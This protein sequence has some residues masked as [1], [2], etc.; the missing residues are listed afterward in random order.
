MFFPN[1]ADQ[2]GGNAID[3][4]YIF[5]RGKSAVHI[6]YNIGVGKQALTGSIVFDGERVFITFL[7]FQ[8]HCFIGGNE[9][10]AGAETP[11]LVDV[12]ADGL[13]C[14]AVNCR[15]HE[16]GA[17]NGNAQTDDDAVFIPYFIQQIFASC[18]GK[19]I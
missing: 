14:F 5:R 15:Y 10:L 8:Y 4:L 11:Y 12:L 17:K 1:F 16:Q 13:Q 3:H 7:F 19:Y 2:L 9:F 6:L 18:F